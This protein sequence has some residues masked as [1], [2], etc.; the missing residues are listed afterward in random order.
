MLVYIS[1]FTFTARLVYLL[2]SIAWY[3]IEEVTGRGLERL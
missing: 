3:A 1:I 2:F